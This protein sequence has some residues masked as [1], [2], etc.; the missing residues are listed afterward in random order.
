MTKIILG[1]P[2]SF[3]NRILWVAREFR[4]NPLSHEPGGCDVIVEYHTQKIY[5]YDWIKFPSLYISKIWNFSISKIY[6][7]YEKYDEDLQLKIIKQNIKRVFARKYNRENFENEEFKEVWNAETSDKIPWKLLE[8]FDYYRKVDSKTA[9]EE[10]LKQQEKSFAYE[11]HLI[12]LAKNT[13]HP[14]QAEFND[15]LKKQEASPEYEKHIIKT[16][17]ERAKLDDFLAGRD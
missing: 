2:E 9:F 5:G 15:Y 8:E 3:Y 12:E 6:I 16:A 1:L 14:D 13:L 17:I 4:T 7:N 10:Y 11:N